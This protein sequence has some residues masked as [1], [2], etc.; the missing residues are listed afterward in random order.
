MFSTADINSIIRFSTG[1]Q[2]LITAIISATQVTVDISRNLAATTMTF[3]RPATQNIGP[4]PN[5]A[6]AMQYVS[7]PRTW[8]HFAYFGTETGSFAQPFNTVPEGYTAVAVDGSLI[9]K[10]GTSN[11]TGTFPNKSMTL[12]AFGGAVTIGQ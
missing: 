1:Q 9:F 7:G 6:M 2:S 8:V 3:V 11:W 4:R 12:R 10:S 5:L